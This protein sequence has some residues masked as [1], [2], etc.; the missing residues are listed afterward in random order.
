MDTPTAPVIPPRKYNKRLIFTGIIIMLVLIILCLITI[1]IYFLRPKNLK[2]TS[3][4]NEDQN[5]PSY[6]MSYP[7][8]LTPATK[9]FTGE[10]ISATLPQDWKIVEYTDETGMKAY[11][12]IENTTIK[13]LTGIEIY[14]ETNQKIFGINGIDGIGGGG[15]CT[16]LATFPDTQ[17]SYISNIQNETAD[18]GFGTTQ[19]ISYT[20]TVY[21]NITFLNLNMRRV[22]DKIYINMSNDP[23]YFN[24]GCG[25]NASFARIDQFEFTITN[26]TSSYNANAY[27][28]GLGSGVNDTQTLEKLDAILNSVEII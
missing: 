18:L 6:T 7:T 5:S 1:Y 15:G 12:D 14:N 25:I 26:S 17:S 28:I 22:E 13:G 8:P 24:A 4:I 21:S 19:I 20:N 16:Q 2:D 3:I 10:Y 9:E 11:A 27:S 23:L